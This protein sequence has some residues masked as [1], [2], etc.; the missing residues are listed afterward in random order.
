MIPRMRPRPPDRLDRIIAAALRVFAEKGYRRAQMAD[1]AREMGVAPGTLYSYVTSKDGL[2]HLVIDRAFARSPGPPAP[3]LPAPDPAPGA[4]LARLRERLAADAAL[5]ALDAALRRRRAADP[6]RELETIVRDLYE[7]VERAWPG[8]VVLERSALDLPDLARVFYQETRRGLLERLERYLAARSRAGQLRA[9][10]PAAA[11]R[12]VVETV[13]SFAMHRH[14]DPSG[15]TI[16]DAAA[17]E[18]AVELVVDA[19]SGPPAGRGAEKRVRR[20]RRR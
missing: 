7:V 19:L 18:A 6:R 4:T 11:A 10:H 1:V 20:R 17:R 14:R 2:F 3:A 9:S 8:I 13:A 16:D 5:P 12:F 15:W